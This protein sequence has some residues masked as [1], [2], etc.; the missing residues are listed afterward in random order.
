VKAGGTGDVSKQKLWYVQ[1][2][3][4]NRL[5]TGVVKGGHLFL[6]NMD[7][8]AECLELTT[9]KSKWNERLKA[10]GPSGEIW[11]SM[12]LASD[13]IYVVNQSGD[14]AVIK[15]NPEK[16]EVVA[17]NPVGERSNSTLALS[18][19]EIFLRTHRNLRCISENAGLRA[20]AH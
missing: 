15:A 18:N 14:T 4:K 12:V 11:G 7:G 9:G 2:E 6:A 16:F 20:S 19:G 3:R 13:N 17:I 1:R 8:I 5:S 10:T